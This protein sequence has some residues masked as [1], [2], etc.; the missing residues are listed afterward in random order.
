MTIEIVPASAADA[1]VLCPVGTLAFADDALNSHFGRP[2]QLTAAQNEESLN[3]RIHRFKARAEGEG[4]FW[5][6]AIDS[7]TGAV[8][9]YS[10]IFSPEAVKQ[11]AGS[12]SQAAEAL[13]SFMDATVIGQFEEKLEAF[14]KKVLGEGGNEVWCEYLCLSSSERVFG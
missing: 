9:G 3:W 6:K 2:S 13:P 4:K 1:P 8:V 7:D 10:G 12:I 11:K 14:K 5:F